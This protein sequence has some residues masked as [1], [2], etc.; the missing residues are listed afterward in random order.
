M[1]LKTGAFTPVI[2]PF[3]AARKLHDVV[4][5]D[6]LTGINPAACNLPDLDITVALNLFWQVKTYEVKTEWTFKDPPTIEDATPTYFPSKSGT[7]TKTG[8]PLINPRNVQDPEGDPEDQISTNPWRDNPIGVVTG[9]VDFVETAYPEDRDTA[10]NNIRET[11][12]LFTAPDSF[13]FFCSSTEPYLYERGQILQNFEVYFNEWTARVQAKLDT[14]INDQSTRGV[15][16]AADLQRQLDAIPQIRIQFKNDYL[17]PTI[18]AYDYQYYT[19]N[20]GQDSNFILAS[21]IK[22]YGLLIKNAVTREEDLEMFELLKGFEQKLNFISWHYLRRYGIECL[23]VRYAFQ[24]EAGE[25]PCG[26]YF[27]SVTGKYNATMTVLPKIPAYSN[28]GWRL[29]VEKPYTA[30]QRNFNGSIST[31]NRI[32][33]KSLAFGPQNNTLLGLQIDRVRDLDPQL[34]GGGEVH[35]GNYFGYDEGGGEINAT[36]SL[37]YLQVFNDIG[38]SIDPGEPSDFNELYGVEDANQYVY[39]GDYFS[40]PSYATATTFFAD[41]ANAVTELRNAGNGE[42]GKLRF[43]SKTDEIIYETPIFGNIGAWEKFDL[44]YKIETLWADAVAP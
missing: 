4:F 17:D 11:Y 29:D 30:Q 1:K 14:F 40:S 44:T 6:V 5:A 32:A 43:V 12:T 38:D 10:R 19:V 31:V 18:E 2:P 15:L 24:S 22:T 13:Q 34:V 25:F 21:E 28:Y 27:D 9:N 42:V 37:D 7:V 3:W 41:I 39:S 20:N 26:F 23:P 8:I 36:I 33:K 16:W 35:G